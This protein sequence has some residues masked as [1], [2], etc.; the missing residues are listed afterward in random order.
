[1]NISF[2]YLA[3][4][5]QTTRHA[6]TRRKNLGRVESSRWRTRLIL[7]ISQVVREQKEG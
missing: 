4:Q 6:F 2:D 3:D 7:L 5:M 1:M